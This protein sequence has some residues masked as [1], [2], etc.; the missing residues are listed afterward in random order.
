MLRIINDHNGCQESID[1]KND[2]KEARG[3]ARAFLYGFVV[4]RHPQKVEQQDIKRVTNES[5]Y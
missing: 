4:I 2:L 3:S 1:R 5:A